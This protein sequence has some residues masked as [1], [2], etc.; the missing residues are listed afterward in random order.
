MRGRFLYVAMAVV[1]LAAVVFL[2]VHR[3][4][5]PGGEGGAAPSMEPVSLLQSDN[6]DPKVNFR[7]TPTEGPWREA[8]NDNLMFS[9]DGPI[10]VTVRCIAPDDDVDLPVGQRGNWYYVTA[11]D[12]PWPGTS[13]YVWGLLV[14]EP[15]QVPACDAGVLAAHPFRPGRLIVRQGPA[16]EGGGYWYRI[17]VSGFHP[18]YQYTVGCVDDFEAMDERF[19]DPFRTFSIRTDGNGAWSGEHDCFRGQGTHHW[20]EI[21]PYS[22]ERVAW[23]TP[24][25]TTRPPEPSRTTTPPGKT[26]P[27]PPT[28]AAPADRAIVV[29]NQVTNGGSAMREDTPAYLS[30]RTAP[31]CKR[32]GAPSRAPT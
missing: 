9:L 32:D 5:A 4:G 7:S 1:L 13:G 28:T 18:R 6:G 15:G 8:Q 21:G 17:E 20:A 25:A 31:Y 23:T 24:P 12:G 14:H 3:P 11:L 30:T 2:I 16:A 19:V 27:P 29:Q 22:S 26:T 10:H